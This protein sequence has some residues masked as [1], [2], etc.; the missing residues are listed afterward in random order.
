MEF[1]FMILLIVVIIAVVS[2]NGHKKVV[3]DP[4][5]LGNRLH[6]LARAG[7]NEK[8]TKLLME[9]PNWSVR[10]WLISAAANLGKL[11]RDVALAEPAG[12]PMQTM[13]LAR[14]LVEQNEE[15]V[16]AIAVRV[17]SLAQ[18]TGA[19]KLRKLPQE[20]IQWINQDTYALTNINQA[21]YDFCQSLTVAIAK[22]RGVPELQNSMSAELQALA[23]AV[24]KVSD[25]H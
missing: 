16:W 4:A 11:R 3:K 12:V 15:A 24:R 2:E 8:V 5:R 9:L 17:A 6:S 20:A 14:Q 10:G 21:A 18:Q 22:G 23:A 25:L 7:K 13:Q 1:I 19:P